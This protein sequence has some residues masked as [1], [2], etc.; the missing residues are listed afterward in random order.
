M[1][2]FFNRIAKIYV[3]IYDLKHCGKVRLLDNI[4]LVHDKNNDIIL[5]IEEKENTF[6]FCGKVK[7]IIKNEKDLIH[8]INELI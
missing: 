7:A 8:V 1:K 3:V 5:L 4:V 6:N 2:Y